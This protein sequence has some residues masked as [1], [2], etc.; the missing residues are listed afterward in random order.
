MEGRSLQFSV[1]FTLVALRR[2][3]DG[4]ATR[5]KMASDR[6]T[7]R[8]HTGDQARDVQARDDV[9]ELSPVGLERH[10]VP[11]DDMADKLPRS[12]IV[13]KRRQD[14]QG[15][16]VIGSDHSRDPEHRNYRAIDEAVQ[17]LREGGANRKRLILVEGGVR[18]LVPGRDLNATITGQDG[19]DM[20]ALCWYG[21]EYGIDVDSP[22]PDTD[23][24]RRYPEV[25][26]LEKTFD[27]DA[28]ML[29][30]FGRQIP[31]YNRTKQEMRGEFEAYMERTLSGYRKAFEQR[32]FWKG[33]DF[34]YGNLRRIYDKFYP[35]RPF[36]PNDSEFF[37]SQMSE[38]WNKGSE[39]QLVTRAANHERD[40]TL[41]GTLQQHWREGTSLVCAMGLYH[42]YRIKPFLDTLGKQG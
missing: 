2:S 8:E 28:I 20:A 4:M 9:P 21:Q 33:F 39:V 26:I 38:P 22:E 34:S 7:S 37:L 16:W 17:G 19:G 5:A 41:A 24:T 11:Y 13:V 14:E 42:V 29:Y 35:E 25:R 12:P 27:R 18:D 23:P 15:M 31:Q 36:D 3:R 1:A 6:Q 32:P 40:K 30:Y 10:F